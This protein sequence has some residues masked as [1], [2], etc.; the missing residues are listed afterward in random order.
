MSAFRPLIQVPQSEGSPIKSV[1][2]IVG[3][4]IAVNTLG[5]HLDYVVREALHQKGLPEDGANLIVV[6]PTA[7]S[8]ARRIR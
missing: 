2:D 5:A 8:R 4:T 6:A 3:K 7:W 1:E